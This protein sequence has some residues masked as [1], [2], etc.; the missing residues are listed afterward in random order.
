MKMEII[1]LRKSGALLRNL[2]P[3]KNNA[4]ISFLILSTNYFLSY[5]ISSSPKK[6][7]NTSFNA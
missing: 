2:L 5:N 4:E 6:L 3:N 7:H 1:G